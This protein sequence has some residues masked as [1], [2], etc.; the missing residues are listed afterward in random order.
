LYGVS[1]INKYQTYNKYETK[2]NKEGGIQSFNDLIQTKHPT[3]SPSEN[4]K[5]PE[6]AKG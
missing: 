6:R 2:I 3:R 5:N 4:K 1:I